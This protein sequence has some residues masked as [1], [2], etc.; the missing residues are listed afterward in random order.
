MEAVF[1]PEIGNIVGPQKEGSWS[2]IFWQEPQ[3]RELQEKRGRLFLVLVISLPLG[4]SPPA[5]LAHALWVHLSN[6]FYG[7]KEGGVL[8][9]L[10]G[11]VSSSLAWL[12]QSVAPFK[13]ELA[14]QKI[15]F[16]LVTGSLWGQVLYLAQTGEASVKIVRDGNLKTILSSFEVSGSEIFADLHLSCASGFLKNHDFVIFSTK[17]F[18]KAISDSEILAQTEREL[19]SKEFCESISPRIHEREDA[20]LI[21]ALVLKMNLVSKP[22]SEEAITFSQVT[23]SKLQPIKA[24]PEAQIGNFWRKFSSNFKIPIGARSFFQAVAK[25]AFLI[26]QKIWPK[27]ELY[28]KDSQAR[29]AFK[30]RIVA[31]L[32]VILIFLFLGSISW[33]LRERGKTA[34]RAKFEEFYQ[35][36]N[37]EVDEAQ[38]VL[39]LNRLRSRELLDE[40]QNLLSEAKR[41][42]VQKAK[43]K[44]LAEKIEKLKKQALKIIDASSSPIF[45]DLSLAKSQAKGEKIVLLGLNLAVL[46][47]LNGSVYTLGREEKSS[48]VY[49]GDFA[50]GRF[51][52]SWGE[53]LFILKEDEGVFELDLTSGQPKKVLEKDSSWGKIVDFF[54]YNDNL[55]VL[56][57]QKSQIWKYPGTPSGF[58][59]PVSFIKEGAS[60]LSKSVSFAIDGTVWVL[61]EEQGMV[62]IL[63]G[64]AESI[65]ISG[66]DKPLSYPV[67]I[68]TASEYKN[69]YVLDKGNKR[70]VVIN[71]DGDYDSQYQADFLAGA[72][73]FSVDEKAG[74]IFVLL[75][76][77]IY[78]VKIQ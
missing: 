38:S 62:K 74:E 61:R 11:A 42:N 49:Q 21:A 16:G 58:G 4:F 13:R 34:Q 10:E 70:I 55:Y 56:D 31:I 8:S 47:P 77:K 40:A 1:E 69:I 44:S 33:G 9:A 52:A 51:T 46:D 12:D 67:A 48:R 24:Q 17:N 19:S 57:S 50:K 73:D 53:R 43:I 64:S 72:Q 37:Q 66:L 35:K 14:L 59:A 71:K 22:T 18:E 60:D 39:E 6:S 23:E 32:L 2:G 7:K 65:D 63:P 36:A 27:R 20:H 75:G 5:P 76:P 26:W 30:K 28:L 68:D 45:F 15:N 3:E 25:K 29:K 54:S 41:L 78:Q